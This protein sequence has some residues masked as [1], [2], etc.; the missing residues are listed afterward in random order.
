[1]SPSVYIAKA[2]QGKTPQLADIDKSPPATPEQE[3]HIKSTVGSFRYYA[4]AVAPHLIGP[5]AHIKQA[6]TTQNTVKQEARF[7]NWVYHHPHSRQRIYP[8]DMIIHGISDAAF[9]TL[10][11]SKSMASGLAY[12]GKPD[13]TGIDQPFHINSPVLCYA[14]KLTHVVRTAHEAEYG[15]IYTLATKLLGCRET[16]INLGHP[17]PPTE[18]SSDNQWATSLANG[19]MKKQKNSKVTVLEY[20][21]IQDRKEFKTVWAPGKNNLADFNSKLQPVNHY[22]AMIPKFSDISPPVPKFEQQ[23]NSSITTNK[24]TFS[25]H[26]EIIPQQI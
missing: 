10:E 12:C 4:N 26:V 8:S 11:G 16:L 7:L 1:L 24:I 19:T 22:C 17:Q 15:A 9:N 25:P 13:Y 23:I 5:I 21:W 20:H 18:I 14:S 3:T 6:S 2:Y